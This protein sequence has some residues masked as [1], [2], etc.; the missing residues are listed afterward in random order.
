M[1]PLIEIENLSRYYGNLRAVRDVSFELRRGEILGFLGPNGAGKSTT[2]GMI[3]GVLAPSGG[4]IRL[5]GLDLLQHPARAKAALGYLPEQPPLYTEL[6][7]DEY[8][9]FCA[10]LRGAG[11]KEIPS[12]V[13]QAKER[14]GLESSGG[15]L[16]ANLSKGY[17]QRVGIAQAII[18]HPE[19]IILDEPT[20]GLDPNQI[21]EIRKL[22]QELGEEHGVILSTHILS[23]VESTCDRVLILHEGRVVY[24]E[25]M[26]QLHRQASDQVTVRLERPPSAEEL[27]QLPGITYVEALSGDRFRLQLSEE[28]AAAELSKALSEQGWGLCEFT[29][30]RQDLEQIFTRLTAREAAA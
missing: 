21:Q 24:A 2:M 26:A 1:P 4:S 18:H 16:I 23:E 6:T 14:C 3:S 20:S 8:L 7:V 25:Q 27:E 22:I 9:R 17:R 29:P 10:Q 11:R 30:E 13:A 19:I 28:A 15:R 12:Q 5:N